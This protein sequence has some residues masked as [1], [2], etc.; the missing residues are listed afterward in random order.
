MSFLC[1]FICCGDDENDNMDTGIVG[2]YAMVGMS[3]YNCFNEEDNFLWDIENNN[4][5]QNG[6]DFPCSGI[7]ATWTFNSD[8]T[9]NSVVTIE[10]FGSENSAGTYEVKDDNRIIMCDSN[11][12]CET[13]ALR[14]VN[15]GNR[16]EIEGK[17]NQLG[18]SIFIYLS[19]K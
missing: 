3:S 6:E 14:T 12:Y 10:G 17:D 2:A 9:V 18:C 8:G 1:L 16:L 11:N 13:H 7:S 15:G 5:N 4:C 19:K